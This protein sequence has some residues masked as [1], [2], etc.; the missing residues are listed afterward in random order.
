MQIVLDKG[1]ESDWF[2]SHW[3]TAAAVAAVALLVTWVIWEWHHPH[4][5]VELTL[6]KKRNFA[7]AMFFMFVLGMV[8][9]G[10][11]V[12]IPQYLQ[13]LLGYSAESAGEA[14]AGGGFIMMVM[15]PI[16]GISGLE[17]G[18]ARVDVVRLRHDCGRALLHDHA[19]DAWAWISAPPRCCASIRS[20]GLAFIF[21][22]SNTLSYVGVPREKNNQISSM[23]SFVRN[24]GGSIGIAL[25]SHAHHARD[26]DDA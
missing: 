5:I 25:I 24:I 15:M 16:S 11:T 19:H 13:L 12:L 8:L 1:Q 23:I 3:I 18:P 21:I 4:P 7:T 10:T 17:G 14:L 22:P 26:A 9:Y 20:L 2:A 6:L